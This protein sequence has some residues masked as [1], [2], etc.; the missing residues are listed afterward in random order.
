[1]TPA[2]GYAFKV[3]IL[4]VSHPTSEFGLDVQSGTYQAHTVPDGRGKCDEDFD[5][6]I[7]PLCQLVVIIVASRLIE[8]RYFLPKRVEDGVGRVAIFELGK[9]WMGSEVFPGLLPINL[10]G[11]I[12]DR[13]IV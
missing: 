9:E 5:R 6:R 4:E 7:K 12:E 13:L 8:R 2:G 3:Q 1:M 11:I 10:Q